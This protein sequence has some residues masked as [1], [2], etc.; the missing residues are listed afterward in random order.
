[1]GTYIDVFKIQRLDRDVPAKETMKAL[2]DVVESGQVRYLVAISMATWEFQKLEDTAKAHRWLEVTSRQGHYNHLYWG[3]EKEMIAFYRETGVGLIPWNPLARGILARPWL[4]R[5]T[6]SGDTDTLP[7]NMVRG[8]GNFADQI[9][10][11]CVE[12]I[13]KKRGVTAAPIALAWCTEKSVYPV[14]GLG[15]TE[16][17]EQAVDALKIKLNVEEGQY[18]EE[19]YFRS[20]VR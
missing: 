10:F 11:G 4:S 8:N 20:P 13:A 15:S 17:I 3:Q 6:K 1:M 16:R 12:D 9:I 19:P 5:P 2:N 14:A 18:L 7:Q